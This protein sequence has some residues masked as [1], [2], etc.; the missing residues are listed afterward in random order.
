M[1]ED[2]TSPK[3]INAEDE[4]LDQSL[5]PSRLSDYKGQEQLKKNLKIFLQAAKKRNEA[6]E[7][8]LFYGPPGLG[9]T[10]LA[11]I[12]SSEMGVSIR[13]TSGPA[14][15]RAGDLA[16]IRTNLEEHDILLIYEIHRLSKVG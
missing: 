5:R 4:H 8:V 11:H 7:H 16:S 9:K 6:L 1:S 10:T 3:P 2:I 15:E 13:V 12:L 14:I